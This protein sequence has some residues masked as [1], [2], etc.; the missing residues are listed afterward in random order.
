MYHTV[1]MHQMKYYELVWG[2]YVD[3]SSRSRQT[4]EKEYTALEQGSI[5]SLLCQLK[6]RMDKEGVSVTQAQIDAYKAIQI[7][8]PSQA[9]GADVE[10]YVY[11]NVLIDDFL[12]FVTS[13][14]QVL[15]DQHS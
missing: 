7:W 1:Y 15:Q 11:L 10:E 5:A 9:F 6:I 14:F 3:D 12:L 13:V 8:Y 4:F 2:G